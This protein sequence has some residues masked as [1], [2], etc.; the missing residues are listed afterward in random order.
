MR[1][2]KSLALQRGRDKIPWYHLILMLFYNNI[3]IKYGVI[4][5]YSIAI[6]GEPSTPTKHSVC[7]SRDEFKKVNFMACTNRQFSKKSFLVYYFSV[8]AFIMFHII[9]LTFFLVKHFFDFFY[10]FFKA[11]KYLS[12]QTKI[13]GTATYFC[14]IISTLQS[15]IPF[16]RNNKSLPYHWL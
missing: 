10:Y 7:C 3:L 9:C 4:R 15:H 16:R 2:Q 14:S 11:I 8:I 13:S 6:T 12:T 1:T 5:L